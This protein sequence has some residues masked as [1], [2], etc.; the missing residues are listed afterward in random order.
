MIICLSYLKYGESTM[1]IPL[2]GIE[3]LYYITFK[4]KTNH[5]IFLDDKDRADL[6]EVL[7]LVVKRFNCMVHA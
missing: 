5:A 7:C 4:R 1:N 3:A 2:S 6:L